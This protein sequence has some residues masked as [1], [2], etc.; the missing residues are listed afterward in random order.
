M[1]SGRLDGRPMLASAC[2]VLLAIAV[3]GS[4]KL[5]IDLS[6]SPADV[7]TIWLGNAIPLAIML[8]RP[9]REWWLYLAAAAAGTFSAHALT[10]DGWLLS[11]GFALCSGGEIAVAAALLAASRAEDILGSW[12]SALLFLGFGVSASTALGSL[13][14]VILSGPIDIP[15][16]KVWHSWWMSDAI[17]MLLVTPVLVALLR[18]DGQFRLSLPALA[19]F[20]AI[21]AALLAAASIGFVSLL[22]HSYLGYIGLMAV[23]PCIVWAA[24]R[25]GCGGAALGNLLVAIAAAA[26]VVMAGLNDE[27]NP[28]ES[29]ELVQLT[30]LAIAS[31]SLLFA[32]LFAERR[33]LLARLNDAIESMSEG[34]ILFDR[35]DCFVL[36]NEN[37]REM[38]SLSADLLVPG[39]S[40]ED[41]I[42]EGAKRGQYGAAL[43]RIE[44]WVAEAIERHRN[45][46]DRFVQEVGDGRWVQV[47]ERWT[48]D[49]GYVGVRTD[50]TDLKQKEVALKDGEERLKATIAKLEH[51]ELELRRQANVL[52]ELVEQNA[53]QREQAMAANRAKSEFL[54]TMSHEIR[55]PLNGIVGYTELLLDSPLAPEQRRHART[56]LECGTALVTVINDVLDFSKIEAGK[57][58][59]VSEQFDVVDVIH[60]VASIARAAA[61][62]KGL[63]LSVT[64]G[65]GVPSAVIGDPNRFRQIVLNLV[66]NAVKF[67]DKGTVDIEADLIAATSE[68]ATIRVVVRDT[69]IGISAEAQPHLFEK[70]Y[71]A[72]TGNRLQRGGTGLGLAISKNLVALMGG[73]IGFESTQG[74]GSRF[75]FTVTLGRGALQV[76]SAES[77]QAGIDAG[78]PARVLLVD[79]LDMNRDIALTF[80]SQAGHTVDTAVDGA[81]ALAAVAAKDYDL[82]LMDVQ[83][84]IMDGLEA[85]A[86]IRGMPAPKCD[87]PIVAMTAYATRQDVERCTRV[88][89]NAHVSK[90]IAKR[91]LLEA[92]NSYAVR[93]RHASIPVPSR[94]EGELFNPNAVDVLE[95]DAGR[96]KMLQLVSSISSRLGSAI[97]RLHRDAADGAFARVHAEAHKLTSSTG[98]IGLAR[99]SAQRRYDAAQAHPPRGLQAHAAFQRRAGMPAVRVQDG[100][101]RDEKKESGRI[102]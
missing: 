5:G 18:R 45:P 85:T 48:H 72:E 79:D 73:E 23:L 60:G 29:L 64:I 2:A 11:F 76:A 63:Q 22:S 97:E 69:G 89:M 40:F 20:V 33:G 19:E 13:S 25:F 98:L 55:S 101:R 67:T 15:Y 12:R 39:R 41:I 90:P 78:S 54:A 99:L 93:E 24:A 49:G 37:Y 46:G 31:T 52:Q 82:V 27:G 94:I 100:R 75:W 77:M 36:C 86:R 74:I 1:I 16:L 4:G 65:D 59:L 17:G 62:N 81:E 96:E 38:F 10:G 56:V 42:R 51:S 70:F 28:L 58:D 47:C 44:E 8:V 57:F 92:V 95:R 26:A 35:N 66:T 84:P 30:L 14:S 21:A 91:A 80:L 71:Q 68:Q 6:R 53:T 7:A 88:G 50:V 87:I 32:V 9:R 102:I 43:G 3:F 83:M 61:E 34:F